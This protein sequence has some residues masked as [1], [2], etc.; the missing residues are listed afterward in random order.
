MMK[1]DDKRDALEMTEELFAF[2]QGEVPEGIRFGCDDEVPTL[3]ADQAWS[4]IWF[5]GNL[6]WQ[7][8]DYIER[9]D[10]CGTLYNS[11]REGDCLD[12]GGMPYSFCQGCTEGEEY[13]DKRETA[14]QAARD[15]AKGET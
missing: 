1:T 12:Y 2:L 15:A 13:R 6:Y 4:V 8:T 7:V 3:S 10:V 11:H 14:N 9:C 5:L